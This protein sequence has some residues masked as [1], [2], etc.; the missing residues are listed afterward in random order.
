[1][2]TLVVPVGFGKMNIQHKSLQG[3]VL[4]KSVAGTDYLPS[5]L[6]LP[7]KLDWLLER[8]FKI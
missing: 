7:L 4:I 6:A 2:C 5:C 3:N 8:K 1:L